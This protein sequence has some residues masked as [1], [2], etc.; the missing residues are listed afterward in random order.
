[1]QLH[2]FQDS[3]HNNRCPSCVLSRL[4]V[5]IKLFVWH[6]LSRYEAGRIAR[7][8]MQ[9]YEGLREKHAKNK[10]IH[11]QGNGW[12]ILTGRDFLG[13]FA[14][15]RKA[16]VNFVMSVR[17]EELGCHWT[18]FHEIRYLSVFRRSVENI[19]I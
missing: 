3:P 8:P 16:T 11:Y 6:G 7:S 4:E 18:N 2:N 15:L 19:Q 9:I 10:V 17:M 13:A 1:M 12:L 14:K 5:A